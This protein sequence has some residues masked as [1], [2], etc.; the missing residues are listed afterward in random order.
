MRHLTM[1]TPLAWAFMKP[2]TN[3]AHQARALGKPSLF[4]QQRWLSMAYFT[5]LP[6]IRIMG[7][8]VRCLTHLP[9]RTKVI[10]ITQCSRSVDISLWDIENAQYPGIPS[11]FIA[12]RSLLSSFTFSLLCFQHC[13]YQG[14]FCHIQFI[15][16]FF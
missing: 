5:A 4:K 12:L 1:E 7:P 11:L 13:L 6:S 3:H 14:R 2:Y 9:Q 15:K 10:T 8:L 16:S